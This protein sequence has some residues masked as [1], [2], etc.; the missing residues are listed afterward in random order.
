MVKIALQL[1]VT[2][3]NVGHLQPTDDS[4]VWYLKVK[5]SGCGEVNDNWVSVELGSRHVSF[6][7]GSLMSGLV[8]LHGA[9]AASGKVPVAPTVPPSIRTVPRVPADSLQCV[10]HLTN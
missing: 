4:F 5:C 10:E 9:F 2:F 8:D 3:D 7:Y 1:N 6:L